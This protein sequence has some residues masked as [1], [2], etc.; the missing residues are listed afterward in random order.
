MDRKKMKKEISK[1]MFTLIFIEGIEE[2]KNTLVKFILKDEKIE[3]LGKEIRCTFK[4][5]ELFFFELIIYQNK[6]CLKIS[7][8]DE[9]TSKL[10]EILV[11]EEKGIE[12]NQLDMIFFKLQDIQYRKNNFS[13]G[14]VVEDEAND[15]VSIVVKN[16][17]TG[18]NVKNIVDE[19]KNTDNVE[20]IEIENEEVQNLQNKS[21]KLTNLLIFTVIALVVVT[22]FLTLSYY[23]HKNNLKKLEN[24]I[25]QKGS[26]QIKTENTNLT[27]KDSMPANNIK[28]SNTTSNYENFEVKAGYKYKKSNGKDSSFAR[29][30][31]GYDSFINSYNLEEDYRNIQSEYCN[32]VDEIKK[33]DDGIV[34]GT[35]TP[36]EQVTYK[37]V[38]DA[39]REYLQQIAQIRQVI[40][41]YYGNDNDLENSSG[42]HY[43]GTYWNNANSQYKAKQFYSEEVRENLR[44]N[45]YE[46]LN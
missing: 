44:N 16:E 35:N 4:Y 24:L 1:N 33:V 5:D 26:N 18:S 41:T 27:Q 3:I 14:V 23:N 39:Y 45:G 28:N 37:E 10:I 30:N 15:D 31:L 38:D 12:F 29:K 36:F 7:F 20:N 46:V 11:A 21:N 42:C 6:P 8:Q 43:T 13:R 40:D 9:N 19:D 22:V 2:L 34:P 25:N 32:A 17:N